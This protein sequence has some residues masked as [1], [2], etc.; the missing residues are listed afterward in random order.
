MQ[1]TP[2]SDP[3]AGRELAMRLHAAGERLNERARALDHRLDALE[4][5]GPAALR[6]R[7]AAAEH[8]LRDEQ[9]AGELRD[10]ATALSHSCG[11]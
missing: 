9:I 7:I 3:A 8:K 6:L 11:G 4:F 10:V 5:E 1:D 2:I